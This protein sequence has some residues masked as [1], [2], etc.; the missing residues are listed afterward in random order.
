[1]WPLANRASPEP[2]ATAGALEHEARA[3]P[4]LNAAPRRWSRTASLGETERY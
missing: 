2:R 3:S 1:L 4:A